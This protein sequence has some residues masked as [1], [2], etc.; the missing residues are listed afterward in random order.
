MLSGGRWEVVVCLRWSSAARTLPRA[1]KFWQGRFAT[2][3]TTRSSMTCERQKKSGQ[4]MTIESISHWLFELSTIT[5]VTGQWKWRT[6][7]KAVNETC[8]YPRTSFSVHHWSS[9]LRR[10]SSIIIH[11]SNT[12]LASS[13]LGIFVHRLAMTLPSFTTASKCRSGRVSTSM[14]SMGFALRMSRSA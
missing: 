5:G 7:R 8:D 2:H 3:S 13:S 6:N 4:S 9:S 1:S 12:L 14:S 11:H 10:E